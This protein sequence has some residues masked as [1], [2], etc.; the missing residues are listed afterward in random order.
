M[1]TSNPPAASTNAVGP[2]M[3]T[4]AAC[5]FGQATWRTMSRSILLAY[6][7]QPGG[8]ARVSA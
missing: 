4:C 7:F 6:P 3:K 1:S 2:Q 5:S 8:W